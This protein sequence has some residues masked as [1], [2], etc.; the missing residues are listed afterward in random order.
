MICELYLNKSILVKKKKKS[1]AVNFTLSQALKFPGLHSR[2][3]LSLTRLCLHLI[4]DGR[5]REVRV[6]R[7]NALS[8]QRGYSMSAR[9]QL[10]CTQMF[11]PKIK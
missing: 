11:I 10:K 1:E 7:V 2:N 6:G 4:T 9:Q 5:Q 3:V 8:A